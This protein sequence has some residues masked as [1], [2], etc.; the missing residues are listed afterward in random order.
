MI[1]GMDLDAMLS[2]MLLRHH[3]GWRLRGF[4]DLQTIYHDPGMTPADLRQCIWVDLDIYHP[5]IASIGHHILSFRSGDSLPG[6]A[7]TLNPNLL[8]GMSYERFAAKYP[9]GTVHFLAWV[10]GVN[11]PAQNGGKY[12]FWLPDSSWIN[13]QSHR[14][15]KNVHDW[16]WGFVE[17][18]L[19]KDT[20]DDVDTIKFEGD[21]A[22][23]F[24]QLANETGF[25]AGRGQVKSRH[26]Q[27]GGMQCRMAGV[28]PASMQS[29]ARLCRFVHERTGWHTDMG[30]PADLERIPGRRNP[31]KGDLAG[32]LAREQVFSYVIPNADVINYT[33]FD[34]AI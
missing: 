22:Q 29:F 4:Y 32:F 5:E 28:D 7:R 6:H 21:I 15:R 20:F 8:R 24:A 23:F 30:T 26:M 19:L 1:I 33:T 11:L 10:L 12:L 14:F 18:P 34:G 2:A 9:L 3:L 16:L 13:A 27:I 31:Y 25:K 17:V